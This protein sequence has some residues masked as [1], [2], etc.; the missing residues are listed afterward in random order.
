MK[1]IR[2][3]KMAKKKSNQ[4]RPRSR[5]LD[6]PASGK[7]NAGT[8]VLRPNILDLDVPDLVMD[9]ATYEVAPRALRT[10]AQRMIDQIE[11]HKHLRKARILML[12][13]RSE[14]QA[15][16]LEAGG[17]GAGKRVSV[18]HA[19]I[20][21]GINGAIA[22]MVADGPVPDFVIEINGDW[23]DSLMQVAKAENRDPAGTKV[24]ISCGEVTAPLDRVHAAVD[25][26]TGSRLK[27]LIDHELSHCGAR[28]KQVWVVPAD[29]DAFKKDMGDALVEV[30]PEVTDDTSGIT[31]IQ[32]VILVKN[33]QDGRWVWCMRHHEIEEFTSVCQR[34][35]DECRQVRQAD[36]AE[37]P[38]ATLFDE[39]PVPAAA[40]V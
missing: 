17:G 2:R 34:W 35:P 18:G 5:A 37:E 40:A 13:K 16:A 14:A 1:P 19:R 25:V 27:R 23:L 20:V 15:K 28:T 10:T 11:D 21:R 12:V 9:K 36:E 39:A 33:P 26:L 30:R 38:D 22:R 31:K 4:K 3:I 8:P 29:V 7:E 6:R 24:T 32:A